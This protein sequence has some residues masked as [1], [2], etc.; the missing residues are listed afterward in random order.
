MAK[1]RNVALASTVALLSL[2]LTACGNSN[3]SSKKSSS[4]NSSTETIT[5]RKSSVT[6]KSEDG[7]TYKN[8][9]FKTK[10]LTY[11]FTKTELMDSDIE[12]KDAI[13][14]YFNVTN[15]SEK[16]QLPSDVYM[17]IHAYQ[18][19]SSSEVRLNPGSIKTDENNND[20]LQEY[21][22]NLNNKLLPKKTVKAVVVFILKNNK[23]I[24]IT[25]ENSNF[26]VI[27]RKIYKIK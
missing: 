13:V 14:M 7:W 22:D 25:F 8:S 16:K 23:P 19:T 12:G 17:Y 3:S 2:G 10:N 26:R 5:K 27:G 9:V 21:N 15:T 4:N 18:N 11:R 1:I 24:K 6:T 20:P